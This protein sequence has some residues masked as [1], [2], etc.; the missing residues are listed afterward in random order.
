M[1]TPAQI[2]K[3]GSVKNCRNSFLS[4]PAI[5]IRL[6]VWDNFSVFFKK[7]TWGYANEK[8][9][10]ERQN[11]IHSSR[12][13]PAFRITVI[14][15]SKHWIR[16]VGKKRFL[17]VLSLQNNKE[18]DGSFGWTFLDSFDVLKLDLCTLPQMQQKWLACIFLKKKSV[19]HGITLEEKQFFISRHL[20]F[21]NW[22][23]KQ[24]LPLSIT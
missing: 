16:C 13:S 14:H 3:Y 19:Y 8:G 21:S 22:Y 5:I 24:I 1:W 10:A 4:A 9:C 6:Q 17:E 15:V 20:R 23:I 7:R 11:N 2:N 18:A 12:S